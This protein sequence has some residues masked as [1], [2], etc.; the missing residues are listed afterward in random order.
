MKLSYCP[1]CGNTQL[2]EIIIRKPCY[3]QQDGV[4]VEIIPALIKIY[5]PDCLWEDR[6]EKR[7]E[8]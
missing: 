4:L 1:D 3:E 7:D 8:S 2:R 5:C 6:Y